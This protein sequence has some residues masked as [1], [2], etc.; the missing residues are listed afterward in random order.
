[1]Q[2]TIIKLMPEKG[3]GFIRGENKVEYFFH[4]SAL[5]NVHLEELHTGQEVTF[6]DVE[7]TIDNSGRSKGPRAE[8]V[9]V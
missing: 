7:G 6:E 2:G 8:D 4:R 1:M 5:K 9:F 3:F